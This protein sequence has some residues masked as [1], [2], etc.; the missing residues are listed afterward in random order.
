MSSSEKP[1]RVAVLGAGTV[2]GP[3]VRA[4]LDRADRLTPFDGTTLTLTAVADKFTDRVIASGIPA[5]IVTDAPAHVVAA[6]D[7][8]VVVEL[9]GGNE[10]AHTL[11]AAAL[12]AGKSVVTANKHV[13]AHHGP[14]FEAL[15]RA[16]GGAFRF[17]AAVGGGTPVLAPIAED[18]AANEIS[19]VRGIVNGT[20]NF[21]LTA[22][23]ENGAAYADVLLEAQGRG[24]AEADPRGDVEGDDAVNKIVI[25]ARLAFGAWI[26]PSDVQ[27]APPT[28]AGSDGRRGITGVTADEV[29][30]AGALG[31]TLRLVARTE[32]GADG[33]P[34][35]SV[36]PSAVARFSPLGITDWVL[37]RIDYSS[38]EGA[39]PPELAIVTS[40]GSG[41]CTLDSQCSDG[42]FCNGIER[43]NTGTCA[44]GAVPDCNDGVSCTSDSCDIASDQCI[45]ATN[46]GLCSNGLF[47]DGTEF[48]D[49]TAGAVVDAES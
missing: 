16:N 18:L 14:E 47:C 9:M 40:A 26:A 29:A 12:A 5:T 21:I 34:V 48:C 35:A 38:K 2:G 11:V 3:V 36:L 44:A 39:N 43:C 10:P 15:A 17:E 20:T 22:M 27:T 1:L 4:L 41:G 28:L 25:L 19:Q 33:R 45:H 46:H 13:V 49:A 6:D 30:G 7:N 23:R 37:N 42:I 32:R 31:L 24:Y 8:D